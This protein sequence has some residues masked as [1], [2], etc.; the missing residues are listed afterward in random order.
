VHTG[1]GWLSWEWKRGHP[2]ENYSVLVL[3]LIWGRQSVLALNNDPTLL[4]QLPEL[5]CDIA[6][7]RGLR[8]GH[9][10]KSLRQAL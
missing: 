4:D 3:Y 9:Q 2:S 5:H 10:T 1:N 8:W 7:L 6:L